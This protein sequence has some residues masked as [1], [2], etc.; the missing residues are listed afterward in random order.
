MCGIPVVYGMSLGQQLS[1]S[2]FETA[3]A[4]SKCVSFRCHCTWSWLQDRHTYHPYLIRCLNMPSHPDRSPCPTT[5]ISFQTFLTFFVFFTASIVTFGNL[6]NYL[7]SR[8]ALL[9]WNVIYIYMSGGPPS[10]GMSGTSSVF[11][12]WI[13]K[14]LLI[15]ICQQIFLQWK[16]P[17][18]KVCCTSQA[19]DLDS[20]TNSILIIRVA[21]RLQIYC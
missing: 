10:E 13:T 11:L 15:R 17:R 18:R 21:A 2:L 6:I 9:E 14:K 19:R 12:I 16:P 3:L 20:G 1:S 8:N 7:I 4:K 5:E